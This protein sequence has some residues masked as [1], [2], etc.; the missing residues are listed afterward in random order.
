MYGAVPYLMD[1]FAIDRDQAFR[2]VCEWLDLES[3]SVPDQ[4]SPPAPA[5][6]R[7]PRRGRSRAA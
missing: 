4:G 7:R 1:A 3:A 2:I 6:V 5:V